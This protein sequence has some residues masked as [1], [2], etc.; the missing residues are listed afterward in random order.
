M[1]STV[2]HPLVHRVLNVLEGVVARARSRF[3]V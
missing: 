1:T 2:K 3:T